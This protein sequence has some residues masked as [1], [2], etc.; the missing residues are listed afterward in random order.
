MITEMKV[1][2]CLV[3]VGYWLRH[4]PQATSGSAQAEASS[5]ESSGTSILTLELGNQKLVGEGEY[6]FGHNQ[7]ISYLR[8]FGT[9]KLFPAPRIRFLSVGFSGLW[10]SDK[11]TLA[12]SDKAIPEWLAVQFEVFQKLPKLTFFDSQILEASHCCCWISDHPFFLKKR[13]VRMH[14][15][16]CVYIYIHVHIY[17]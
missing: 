16:I 1:L 3:S 12:V 14:T 13:G 17:R 9:K 11:H 4:G 15:C 7:R 2:T 6:M 10:F 5:G 8:K